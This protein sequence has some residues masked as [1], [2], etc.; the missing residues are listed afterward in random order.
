MSRDA[1]FLQLIASIVG[2]VLL[3]GLGL[4]LL[5]R[6]LVRQFGGAGKWAALE[7]RYAA[8]ERPANQ[9]TRDQTLGV[10]PVIYRNCVAVAAGADG[11]YLALPRIWPLS[12]KK[13]L[14][15]PWNALKVGDPTRLYWRPAARLVIT[16]PPA[17]IIVPAG[18]FPLLHPWLG[19]LV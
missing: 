3:A 10:G 8:E 12:R 13:P 16:E 17:E 2:L 15:I 14:L 11:L 9:T 19:P 4:V 1:V 5:L 6:L 7:T 18:M